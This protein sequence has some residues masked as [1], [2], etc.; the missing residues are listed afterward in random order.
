MH[1][2]KILVLVQYLVATEGGGHVE[3][4]QYCSILY[5]G[6]VELTLIHLFFV[7]KEGLAVEVME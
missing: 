7:P 1:S 2:K 6:W 5:G 3:V 4:R